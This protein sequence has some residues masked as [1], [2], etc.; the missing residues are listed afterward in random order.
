ML[1]P[2]IIKIDTTSLNN[3]IAVAMKYSKRAPAIAVNVAAFFIA[4]QAR[5]D[6]PT[7]PIGRMDTELG[8]ISTPV[9]S[10]RGKR[11][12]L[13]LK[14]GK[15][16]ISVNKAVAT[17][18]GAFGGIPLSWLLISARAKSGSK[19]N[20]DTA[21]RFKIPVHPL[22]GH[23]VSEF[24]SLMAAAVQRMV[25]SRHSSGS[26]LASGWIPVIEIMEKSVP[27]KYRRLAAPYSG[28]RKS[29]ADHGTAEPAMQESTYAVATISNEIGMSGRLGV[30]DARRNAALL[31]IAGPI[32]QSAIEKEYEKTMEYVIKQEFGDDKA[33]YQKNGVIIDI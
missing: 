8:V 20:Q 16:N 15:K 23:K 26:F 28:Q 4:R 17:V 21:G 1:A 24:A 3:A 25:S 30:L 18:S 5:V 10:T 12:G 2:Q 33:Q 9:L 32:L 27:S 22:K 11:K 31:A 13:P 14:S 7:T 6:T 19:Y 29:S